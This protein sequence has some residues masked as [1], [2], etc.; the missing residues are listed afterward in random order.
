MLLKKVT[1]ALSG[2]GRN[3]DDCAVVLVVSYD[4][5]MMQVSQLMLERSVSGYMLHLLELTLN[6]NIN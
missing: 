3:A 4:S 5:Y 1:V 2:I 6:V